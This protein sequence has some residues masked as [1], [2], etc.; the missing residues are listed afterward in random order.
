MTEVP[1]SPVNLRVQQDDSLP[2]GHGPVSA[3]QGNKEEEFAE[4]QPLSCSG[5][6]GG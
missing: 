4:D 5:S 2:T 6:E 1:I 3:A